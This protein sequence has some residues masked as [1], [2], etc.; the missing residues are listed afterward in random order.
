MIATFGSGAGSRED[1][2]VSGCRDRVRLR[3]ARACAAHPRGFGTFPRVLGRY[4][5]ETCAL[6]LADAVRKM[7][8]LP[9]TIVGMVDRGFIAVGHG[10]GS[11]GVRRRRR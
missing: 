8:G 10:G 2:A 4:V 6:S 3:R 7:T 11:R 1:H 9:A 5:R